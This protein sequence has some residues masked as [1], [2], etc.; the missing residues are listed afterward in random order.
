MVSWGHLCE[1]CALNFFFTYHSEDRIR[2]GANKLLKSKQK[3]TQG[4]LDMF[5]K[6]VASPVAGQKRKVL[7]LALFGWTN[8]MTN[9]HHQG[10]DDKGPLKKK[11]K[12]ASSSG[13]FRKRK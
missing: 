11:S 12:P 6:P 8:L 9:S 4:R 13:S 3:A 1:K 10:N 5:F 2:N 7:K